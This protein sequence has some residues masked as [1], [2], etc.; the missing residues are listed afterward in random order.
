MEFKHARLENGLSVVAEANTEAASLALGFF[1]RTGSR[2]E[3]PEVSG[4]SHFLEHMMF[5]GT[6]RRTPFDVNREFDDMGADYN[7]S[8]SYENTVYYGAVL[9]EHQGRLLDLLS[10]MMRP[11]LRK[12]DFD[13]EK[14]VILEE[15]ALYQDQPKF[16]TYDRLM[17]EFFRGHPLSNEILGSE[18]SI[19][20]MAVEDMR[21][22]FRRRY[23]PGNLTLVGVGNVDFET[24][25]EQVREA[26]ADWQPMEA[27]RETAGQPNRTGMTVV[28]DAKLAREHLGLMS[29][30][31]SCQDERR[32]A[33]Q[34]LSTVVGDSTGSRLFYAL[35]DP[36]IADEASMFY[37]PL[38]HAGGF[39]TF[40]SADLDRAAE[41]LRIAREEFRR[42][43]DEGPT[44]SELSAAK[45]KIASSA[46]LKGEIPMG[47]LGAVGADWVYRGEYEPLA[48]L[49]ERIL[50]VSTR[51]VAELACRC[52]LD[53]LSVVALG[54][55]ERL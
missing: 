8:T 18:E 32:Y 41:A 14:N 26:S 25:V 40:I 19:R 24:M 52:D 50:A 11:L 20:T 37:D 6:D 9:P 38:D 30:A 22:Y 51:E 23:A 34:V 5:K 16:R 33:A 48:D 36:A 3:T 13:V 10:D 15:I 21:A 29:P 31:P 45:N 44:E 7:A 4:V 53:A 39:I 42:F 55:A 49:V 54:P 27:P 47:R 17:S 35:V 43:M 1:A 28:H 2:D 46:T 12:E